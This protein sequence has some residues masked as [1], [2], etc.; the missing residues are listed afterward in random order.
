MSVGTTII[1]IG[2]QFVGES[3]EIPWNIV[4]STNN[5]GVARW[6]WNTYIQVSTREWHFA[7]KEYE[8]P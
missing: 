6:I 5:A 2:R 8:L 1:D 7:G 4:D 3:A